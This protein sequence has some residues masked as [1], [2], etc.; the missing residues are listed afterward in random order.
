[1][2]VKKF[3]LFGDAVARGNDAAHAIKTQAAAVIH[4]K[5]PLSARLRRFFSRETV[6]KLQEEG[7]TILS[8]ASFFVWLLVILFLAYCLFREV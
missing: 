5:V 7:K 6:L 4:P 3:N 8:L 1:M 2:K